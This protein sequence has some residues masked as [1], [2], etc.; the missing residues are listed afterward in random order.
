LV[1]NG[2]AK[3]DSLKNGA[4]KESSHKNDTQISS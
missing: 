2:K 1:K 3:L 4:K